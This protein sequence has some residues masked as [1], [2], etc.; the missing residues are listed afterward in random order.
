M[1][2]RK[3]GIPFCFEDRFVPDRFVTTTQII[4]FH[5]VER[6]KRPEFRDLEKGDCFYFYPVVFPY[7]EYFIPGHI[8]GG[9][10]RVYIAQ[11]V[12][13]LICS[14]PGVFYVHMSSYMYT[15]PGCGKGLG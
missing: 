10:R 12:P 3:T 1:P 11:P 7:V 4:V 8:G 15:K 13:V 9:R 5:G 14:E 2:Q 6:E